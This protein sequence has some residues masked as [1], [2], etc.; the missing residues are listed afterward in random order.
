MGQ[1]IGSRY[2]V[3]NLIGGWYLTLHGLVVIF[4]CKVPTKSTTIGDMQQ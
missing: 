3:S 2:Q 1:P 4:K